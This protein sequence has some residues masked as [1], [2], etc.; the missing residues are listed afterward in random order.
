MI[1]PGFRINWL[2]LVLFVLFVGLILYGLLRDE[3]VEVRNHAS[4]LCLSCIGIE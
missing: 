4:I 3:F 1:K 2:A